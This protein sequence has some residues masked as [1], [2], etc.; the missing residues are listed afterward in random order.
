MAPMS[1]PRIVCILLAFITLLV[2]LPVRHYAF[3]NF[4]DPEYVAGNPMVQAGL[5]WNGLQWAFTTGHAS[6]W[7]PLTWL[8]HMLDCQLFKLNPGRH[9]LVNVLFHAANAVL[10]FL[11]WLRLT[12]ALW[13]SA[14]IAALFAWH[15]LHVES[16]AWVAE[17]KDVL[18]SFFGLLTLLAYSRYAQSG[19][20]KPT[21][22][23]PG[24]V[25]APGAQSS[26]LNYALALLF[27]A[28]GLLSKPMLVTLPLVMLLVD[29]WPLGRVTGGRWQTASGKKTAGRPSTHDPRL[30]TLLAEKWPFF[31]LA[32]ISCAVTFIAQ[33]RGEAVV[34]LEFCPLPLRIENAAVAYVTYLVNCVYPVNLA[35]IYPL[36]KEIP[37]GRVAGA[38]A[39]L[40]TI[41][42]LVWRA[43]QREPY[44][45][46]GWLWY[47]GMLVP[48]VGLVQVGLQSMADRY[49]YLPLVGV[50]A[51][52][53][54]GVANLA[55]KLRLSPI[56]LTVTAVLILAGCLW[57]TTRQLGY[58]PDSETLFKHALWV[59]KANPVA[60]RHL[61]T[62]LS[63]MG[64]PQE[65]IEHFRES[66]RLMPD[67]ALAH[68]NLGGALA[69]TGHPQ[70]ALA[71][72]QEAVRLKPDY[73]VAYFNLGNL[74]AQTGHLPEAIKNFQTALQ[75]QPDFPS[76]RYSLTRALE[77]Q[78]APTNR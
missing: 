71:E 46:T 48:V 7:H 30:S 38:V 44:W 33:K 34:P 78:N 72:F 42:W 50:F 43:R 9:H 8:S 4:D 17:R 23:S 20:E 65:A 27:F 40:V 36:P 3:I 66:L 37:L 10:L 45:L 18:S 26:T 39:V 74:L 67:S 64:Q 32:A 69:R 49:T 61:A 51:G 59:T 24:A 58:W 56:I 2:Y 55:K 68:N 57:T 70:E 5:T 54:F 41:S 6:N 13:P 28:L 12:G 21:T 14:F 22:K 76:A 63:E 11:L 62:A 29:Y 31:L 73:A 47:L 53:T 75:L 52:T 1:R 25:P 15:P 35:V 60:Q 19:I 77:M 16:V